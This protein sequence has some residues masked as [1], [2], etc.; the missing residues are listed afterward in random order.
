MVHYQLAEQ[1]RSRLKYRRTPPARTAQHHPSKPLPKNLHQGEGL[2]KHL[3]SGLVPGLSHLPTPLRRHP[4]A[5][6]SGQALP[7]GGPA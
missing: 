5:C 3:V 7:L 6:S 4:S 1:G 2:G